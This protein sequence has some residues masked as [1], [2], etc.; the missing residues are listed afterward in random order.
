MPRAQR[1]KCVDCERIFDSNQVREVGA[2]LL[3]LFLAVRLS[4]RIRCD[5]TICQKCRSQFLKW[6]QKMEGDFHNCDYVNGFDLDS[7]NND[8]HSVRIRIFIFNCV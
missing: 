7:R 3:R 8:D 1:C 2:G 5:D 4:K 6:Q